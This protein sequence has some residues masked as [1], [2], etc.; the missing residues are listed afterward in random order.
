MIETITWIACAEQM[1]DDDRT[2]LVTGP[3]WE[4][5]PAWHAEL[6]WHSATDGVP[7]GDEMITHWADMPGGPSDPK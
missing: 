7:I 5:W 4:V 6:S 1:P 3:E 2:V